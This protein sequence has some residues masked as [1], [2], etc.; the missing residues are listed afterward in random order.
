MPDPIAPRNAHID[1]ALTNF[2]ASYV[3]SDFIADI[4][5][6]PFLVEKESD[7]FYKRLR[8]DEATPINDLVGHRSKINEV[9][10]DVV[11][12][13]YSVTGRGLAY[14]L[15][16]RTL[17]NADVAL[18]PE[19]T[20][21]NNT[22]QKIKLAREMR[23]A[24]KIMTPGS[25]ANT[26]TGAASESWDDLTD[27]DPIG[28]IQTALQAIPFNGEEVRVYGFC[29]DIVRDVLAT[30]P[31]ILSLRGGGRQEG[32]Q[33][34]EDELAKYL[35]LDGLFASKVHHNSARLGLDP[36]YAR[37]WGSTTFALVVVPAVMANTEQQVFMPTFRVQ[38]EGG[39]NGIRVR[40]WHEAREGIGGTDLFAIELMDDEK[41]VQNDAGFLLTDV[42]VP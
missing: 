26:N 14:A 22:M 20:G 1:A 34:L 9:S 19:Q 23:V 10:Y 11:S 39:E 5:S 12:D 6:P 27:S 35:R 30:H 36:V 37:V 8:I 2:A 28:D 16:E 41:I 42:L 40:R 31:Q 21:V 25:W 24:S 33:M 4:A 13:R 15:P 3:N 38:L 18:T 7:E 29:S 17:K 32:G